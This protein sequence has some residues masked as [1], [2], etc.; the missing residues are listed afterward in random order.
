MRKLEIKYSHLR[1]L[2]NKSELNIAIKAAIVCV[3][4]FLSACASQNES[5][6]QSQQVLN[7]QQSD[8][9]YAEIVEKIV[10]GSA[11]AKDFDL[12][13]RIFPL[14]SFYKPSSGAEQAAKLQSQYFMENENWQACLEVNNKLLEINYSSLTGHYGAS[15]CATELG[16]LEKGRFHNLVL[17]SFIE[18]IW[19]TG[20]GKSPQTALYVTSAND[21]YAFIQL[22]QLVA[23]GQSLVYLNKLPVQVIQVQDPKTNR[24]TTWHFDL[25]SQ[26]RRGLID[27]LEGKQ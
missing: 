17:D 23:V 5:V 3:V 20:D 15:I 4:L 26:F 12:L 7:Y 2:L 21:L 14:T 13:T 11:N 1:D 24:T 9:D 19:R 18:S 6:D 16:N 25:T 8:Q 10:Q 22:H 27:Q